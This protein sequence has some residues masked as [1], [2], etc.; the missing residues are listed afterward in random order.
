MTASIPPERSFWLRND[1][2]TEFPTV[3]AWE[4][5]L[6]LLTTSTVGDAFDGFALKYRVCPISLVSHCRCQ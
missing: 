5:A 6:A 1:C 2:S 4:S 3:E